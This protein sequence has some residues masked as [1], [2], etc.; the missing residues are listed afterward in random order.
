MA[1]ILGK[2]HTRKIKVVA[3]ELGDFD[4]VVARHS[5]DVE[6]RIMPNADWMDAVSGDAMLAD[7]A[8][9][10]MVGVDGVKDEAGNPVPYSDELKAA[11]FNETWLVR[12]ISE[13]FMAVQGG[14]KQADLYKRE[15]R[16]N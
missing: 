3:E 4:A 16:K 6:F 15:K 13:A 9:E 11:L 12:H 8:R 14:G 7:L 5:F 2:K 10:N 1:L